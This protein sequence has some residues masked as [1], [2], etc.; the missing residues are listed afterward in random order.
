MRKI[1]R[2][3]GKNTSNKHQVNFVKGHRLKVPNHPTEFDSIPWNSLI[4]RINNP[5]TSI[6]YG[7]IFTSL[8]SQLGIASTSLLF[9]IRL[10][11]VQIWGPIPTTNTRL[12]VS[13]NDVFDNI[14]G[15]SPAGAQVQLEE[16]TNYADAVNRARVGYVYSSAQQQKS[17]LVAAG[18]PDSV[19]DISGAGNGSVAY[20]H[21]LWRPFRNAAPPAL[22]APS[23][24]HTDASADFDDGIEVI[25]VSDLERIKSILKFDKI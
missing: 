18:A 21:I 1:S 11:R 13:F 6:T 24:N 9:A 5:T 14:S 15:S 7:S 25:S 2:L 22:Q 17:L 16:I 19:C 23:V 12:A 8:T 3:Q 10:Q 20:V 4:V